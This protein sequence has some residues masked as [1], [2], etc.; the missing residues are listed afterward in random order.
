MVLTGK[1]N[2]AL[3][4]VERG[5]NLVAH[6]VHK[7]RASVGGLDGTVTLGLRLSDARGFGGHVDRRDEILRRVLNERD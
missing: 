5:A 4:T 1:R 3:D 7:V 6:L 2:H